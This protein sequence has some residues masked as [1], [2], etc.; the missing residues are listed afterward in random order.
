M[1]ARPALGKIRMSLQMR[2]GNSIESVVPP[3]Q[4]KGERGRTPDRSIDGG[5]GGDGGGD[6]AGAGVA[7]AAAKGRRKEGA[8]IAEL[9]SQLL[10]T[11]TNTGRR[12]AR[13]E[14]RRGA[15]P[16][17][18][19]RNWSLAGGGRFEQNCPARHFCDAHCFVG[20]RE[21]GRGRCSPARTHSRGADTPLLSL[22]H[23]R[24]LSTEEQTHLNRV[25]VTLP[26]RQTDGRRRRGT[27]A[28]TQARIETQVDDVGRTDGRPLTC[29]SS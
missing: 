27:H 2:N 6:F 12:A 14:L 29:R 5:R 20:G 7:A 4:L 16:H 9:I 25:G 28:R 22:L 11:T 15:S 26:D 21:V 17:S 19:V 3:L 13:T 10:T 23:L 18:Q 24:L 8:A 1:S